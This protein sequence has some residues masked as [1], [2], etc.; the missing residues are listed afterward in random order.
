[1]ALRLALAAS[2]EGRHV[3]KE[4]LRRWEMFMTRYSS[5]ALLQVTTGAIGL[6]VVVVGYVYFAP[7]LRES[8]RGLDRFAAES[9]TQ[10]SEGKEL[11]EDWQGAM[12]QIDSSLQRHRSTLVAG[13]EIS[14]QLESSIQRWQS[15]AEG[16]ARV[17]REGSQV[18]ARLS[19]LLPLE[20]PNVDVKQKELEFKIPTWK[21]EKQ[22]VEIPYPT[23]KLGTR[24]RKLDLGLTKIDLDIPTLQI[25][26][27]KQTV[28]LPAPIQA[29][30]RSETVSV[31]EF[32][33]LKM[34][35]VLESEKELL[36]R[37]SLE[38][39]QAS[40]N[41]QGTGTLLRDVRKVVKQ[42]LD[43]SL[44]SAIASLDRAR[45]SLA[46]AKDEKVP[47]LKNALRSQA[48]E[49][50]E[51]RRRFQSSDR[52]IELAALLMAVLPFSVVL[53]GLYNFRRDPTL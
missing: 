43:P 40:E 12:E 49:L 2:R 47:G 44:D 34:E 11:L 52:L 19:N 42:E 45:Q 32:V 8:I 1:M 41:L 18:V 20:I 14:G 35:R 39:M 23:A 15:S 7:K 26:K 36:D 53:Q 27:S 4:Y 31:P 10:L 38:M 46:T 51:N 48:A 13:Q 5:I 17:G 22:S 29:D 25:G 30:F 28:E 37:L 9:Q 16:F 21:V 24:K 3:E 33:D 6:L 50:K